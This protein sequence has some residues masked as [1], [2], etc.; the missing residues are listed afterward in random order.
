M[1]TRLDILFLIYVAAAVLTVWPVHCVWADS[2]PVA[3]SVINGEK[4]KE[5][6]VRAYTAKLRGK[7]QSRWRPAP[8]CTGMAKVGFD[9]KEN[10][11]LSGLVLETS[12]GNET[13]DQ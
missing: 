1:K 3:L 4:G 9:I 6:V 13:F 11:E 12:S 8:G 7:I 10:G 5:E 2:A